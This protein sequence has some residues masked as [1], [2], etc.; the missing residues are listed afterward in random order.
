MNTAVT[1]FIILGIISVAASIVT[2][3]VSN[4]DLVEFNSSVHLSC[5][6]SESSLSFLWL[7]GSSEVTASDRVQLTDGNATLTIFNVTRDDQGPFRC[8]VFNAVTNDTS[9]PV[10]LSIS[11]GP[12]HVILE[13]FPSQEQYVVGS[14][15]NLSCSAVS[16]PSAQF[17]W[18][19]NGDPLPDT[20]P[21]LRLMKIQMNQSGNYSCQA[22][23]NKTLR[24]QTSQ[25]ADITVLDRV[26]I[27]GPTKLEEKQTLVLL[28]SV[29]ST[30]PTSYTWTLNGKEILNNSTV[31]IKPMSESSDSGKY[32]CQVTDDHSG[33]ISF[34]EHSLSVQDIIGPGY[35]NRI[36]FDR[37]TG[38]LELRSLTLSDSGEYRVIIIP[39]GGHQ[40]T[41]STRLEILVPVSNVKVTVSNVDLVEFNSS[42]RLSCSSSGSSLSFLWLNGSSEVTASDRVQLTDGNTNLAIFNVTRYDQGPFRCHVFNAVSNGTS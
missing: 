19:L 18:F 20:G 7:N 37:T 22:F 6:S 25:S 14:N 36:S 21:E 15:L 39:D 31:F 4:V 8:H 12:D 30:L 29:Q 16:S 41:G 24:Y 26:E 11:Y 10:N 33:R 17:Y 13:K 1:G 42:V 32:I 27:L 2:V 5:S 3:T 28:C 35:E 34:G 9:E 23:N 40:F 38:S